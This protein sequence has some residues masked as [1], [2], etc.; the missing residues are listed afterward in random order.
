MRDVP[1]ITSQPSTSSLP[2][3]LTFIQRLRNAYDQVLEEQNRQRPLQQ[4]PSKRATPSERAGQTASPARRSSQ[5][6]AHRAKENAQDLSGPD[7]NPATFEPEK[8]ADDESGHETTT[9]TAPE[10]DEMEARTGVTAPDDSAR[11]MRSLENEKPQTEEESE[12]DVVPEPELPS[13]VQSKL[14]KLNKLEEKYKGSFLYPV[15][16]R[17]YAN[18][19]FLQIY[20]K[21]I[22]KPMPGIHLSS[23]S[24]PNYGR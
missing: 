12:K 24:R 23:P 6:P 16:E 4:S 8:I 20:F 3:A 22:G 15:T 14:R 2:H 10:T 7:P 17:F 13:D 1:G 5:R 19:F 21:H 18:K 9:S 11:E